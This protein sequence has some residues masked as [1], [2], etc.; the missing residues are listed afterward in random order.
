MQK[1]ILS[2]PQEIIMSEPDW[3]TAPEG[4]THWSKENE[5]FYKKEDG[6]M[7]FYR[8]RWIRS[9]YMP[10]E[11]HHLKLIQRPTPPAWHE[12]G[13]LPPVGTECNYTA[14]RHDF[15]AAIVPGEY[16]Y[17]KIIAYYDGFVWTS[18]NGIRALENTIFRPIQSDRDKAIE[19]MVKIIEK[20]AKIY[21]SLED[22]GEASRVLYDASY[23]KPLHP[24]TGEV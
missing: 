23:R 13:D 4:A 17:C 15:H 6:A 18:D 8:I 20:N 21:I 19:E 11:Y 12:T 10:D 1:I 5:L 9:D 16:Y 2:K 24:K 14:K 22:I 7:Y 3:K